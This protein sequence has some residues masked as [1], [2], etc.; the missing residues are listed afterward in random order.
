MH[1]W[2][3][4]VPSGSRRLAP[5]R[6]WIPTSPLPPS[7]CASASLCAVNSSTQLPR[8]SFGFQRTAQATANRPVGV[9]VLGLPTTTLIVRTTLPDLNSVRVRRAVETPIR[10]LVFSTPTSFALTQPAALFGRQGSRTCSQQRLLLA[11]GCP[12][13]SSHGAS[14]GATHVDGCSVLPGTRSKTPIRD[15]I[16][17]FQESEFCGPVTAAPAST[18]PQAPL[19]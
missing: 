17:A 16:S 4:A 19:R 6:P 7:K 8:K 18:L 11:R 14:F 15:P 2:L 9:G 5:P 10:H 13:T 1:P 12:R 3:A